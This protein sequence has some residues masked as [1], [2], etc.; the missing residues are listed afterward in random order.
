MDRLVHLYQLPILLYN[1]EKGFNNVCYPGGYNSL[2]EYS[3][4]KISPRIELAWLSKL[5]INNW[6]PE[7]E[8]EFI[9]LQARFLHYKEV[10][11]TSL[12]HC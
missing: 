1:Q 6:Y 8:I 5:C 7:C 4:A 10:A 12:T 9:V 11:N 3:W 2:K